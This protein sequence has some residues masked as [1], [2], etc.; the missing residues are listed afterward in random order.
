MLTSYALTTAP[1]SHAAV[2]IGG[3][4][5]RHR[6]HG[7]A[8][9]P[10]TAGGPSGSSPPWARSPRSPSARCRT[11]AWASLQWSD[12]LLFGAVLAGAVGYAEG[13]LLSRELGSWQTVSWALVVAAPFMVASHDLSREP[14]RPGRHARR[15]GWRSPTWGSSAC[16]SASS[17]GTAGWPSARCPRSARYSSSSRCMTIAW[18]GLLLHEPI[19]WSTA[20]GGLAVM[21]CAALAVRTRLGLVVSRP[22]RRG[23][24]G[25]TGRA[26]PPAR[27]RRAAGRAGRRARACGRSASDAQPGVGEH[28]RHQRPVA[29]DHQPA[30]DT[31]GACAPGDSL[32]ANRIRSAWAATASASASAWLP[33]RRANRCWDQPPAAV[34]DWT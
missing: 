4:P 25:L 13:G 1:A 17:R 32:S 9:R 20:L 2:V 30:R 14:A 26:P 33:R 3:A 23:A 19:G 24:R 31:P 10:R 29:A 21:A 27:G 12:L 18:A 11:A 8:A 16:S 6:G 15:V 7:G 34:R 22:A 28:L 5:R